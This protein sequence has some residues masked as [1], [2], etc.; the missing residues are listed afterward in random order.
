MS[1][2]VLVIDVVDGF[3]KNP[4]DVF[5][6]VV[7]YKKESLEDQCDYS[8]RIYR[9]WCPVKKMPEKEIVRGFDRYEEGWNE[10]IN[11]ILGEGEDE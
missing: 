6:D 3:F 2:F 4:A 11:E 10:C 5:A 9:C 1:K 7:V 8:Q